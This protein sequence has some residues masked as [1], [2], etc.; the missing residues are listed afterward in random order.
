VTRVQA[1]IV[2]SICDWLNPRIPDAD[3]RLSVPAKWTPADGAL[4]IV[5]DDGGPTLWPIKSQHTIRLTAWASGRTQARAI[6]S[7][8][9]GNLGDGRP[10]GVKHIDP[11]MGAVLD[12]RDE[13][14]GAVLASVLI[15]AQ[16]R[17]VEV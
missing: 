10:P 16:A 7:L 5:A 12:G 13:N 17:T 8:A 11:E 15:V 14:T 2:P 9:A 6:V 1:D 3:V 4:L